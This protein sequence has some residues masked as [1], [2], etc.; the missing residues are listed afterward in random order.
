MQDY[1]CRD[2]SWRP[3]V[4]TLMSRARRVLVDMRGFDPVNKGIQYELHALAERVPAEN[5]VV[6]AAPGSIRQVQALFSRIWS[7]V[8]GAGASGRISLRVDGRLKPN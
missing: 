6:V 8:Q 4:L 2:N 1:Y 3:T 5:I 7:Q